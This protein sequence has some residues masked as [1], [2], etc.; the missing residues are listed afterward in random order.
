MLAERRF[1]IRLVGRRTDIKG[2]MQAK[3]AREILVLW[4]QEFRP[5]GSLERMRDIYIRL[6]SKDMR[7]NTFGYLKGSIMDIAGVFRALL[8]HLGK[9]VEFVHR[10]IY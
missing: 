4:D 7:A 9:Q 6:Q 1:R 8:N 2:F 5:G 10:T 3:R